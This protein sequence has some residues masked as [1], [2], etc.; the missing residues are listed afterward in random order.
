MNTAKQ[1]GSGSIVPLIK[2]LVFTVFVPGTVT[3]YIPYRILSSAAKAVLPVI[4]A[5]QAVGVLSMVLGTLGYFRC[6][7]D[8][9]TSGKGTPAPIDPPKVLVARGLYRFVRNPMYVSALLV[10]F[11]ESLFFESRNLL[12]Y[13]AAFW[14]LAHLFVLLYE[15]PSL[16]TKFGNSYEEYCRAVPRWIPRLPRR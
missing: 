9:A 13:G 12:V 6:A 3:V 10:L 2:T 5:C 15:E 8:F 1:S 16:R 11:G 14:C 4:A 7:W